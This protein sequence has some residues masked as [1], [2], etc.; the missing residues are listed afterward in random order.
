MV[1]LK[2]LNLWGSSSTSIHF[3]SRV[4]SFGCIETL[5]PMI[6]SKNDLKDDPINYACKMF[7][8]TPNKKIDMKVEL[9]V[10]NDSEN[11]TSHMFDEMFQTV[12]VVK[13]EYN[14]LLMF[15]MQLGLGIARCSEEMSGML[16][17]CTYVKLINRGITDHFSR[18]GRASLI[19]TL[20]LF[21]PDQCGLA[22]KFDPGSRL[23]TMFL[24]VTR[25]SVFCVS[26]N[27]L[28]HDKLIMSTLWNSCIW[29][30]NILEQNLPGFL[31]YK[32]RVFGREE[33]LQG[34][35]EALA[36]RYSEQFPNILVNKDDVLLFAKFCI[37]HISKS[38][39]S[40]LVFNSGAN[41]FMVP[42]HVTSNLYVWDPE[43]S[44]E[45]MDLSSY[46]VKV[47]VIQL[48]GCSTC[49]DEVLKYLCNFNYEFVN[50][51]IGCLNLNCVGFA[52]GFVRTTRAKFRTRSR[53]NIGTSVGQKNSLF[54]S[55][56]ALV[57]SFW[58]LIEKV[59]VLESEEEKKK[60]RR[61]EEEEKEEI[62]KFPS[63]NFG[64]GDP[65]E[66]MCNRVRKR[67]NKLAKF[68]GLGPGAMRHPERP[69]STSEV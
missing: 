65:Y 34:L 8:E 44:F 63:W 66:G 19:L 32:S 11:P 18:L 59:R 14:D 29:V 25:N 54:M 53:T 68:A 21:K 31:S 27:D 37:V 20:H 39:L 9:P 16:L 46:L 15:N 28:D 35:L 7:V 38:T 58:N 56:H 51:F 12:S 4:N 6:D 69:K 40:Y 43:K 67:E 23:L 17:T 1:L 50:R 62:N 47:E 24:R 45:T 22:L 41:F 42:I 55:F 60:R 30:D 61:G 64:G 52:I 5:G 10:I 3:P 36:T 33:K 13:G 48:Q 49:P 2:R 26:S 57:T